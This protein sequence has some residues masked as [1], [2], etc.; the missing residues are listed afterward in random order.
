[1]IVRWGGGGGLFRD[2]PLFFGGGGG[3]GG[4][5]FFQDKQLF[6]VSLS[7]QTVFSGSIFL[8]TIFA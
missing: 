5:N 1:M 4:V 6:F 7:V 8:L 2:E 3:E